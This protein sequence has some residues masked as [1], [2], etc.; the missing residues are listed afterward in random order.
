[1]N[2]KLV[3]IKACA[4]VLPGFSTKTAM[5]HETGGTHQL[6]LARHLPDCGPYNFDP[7]DEFRILPR[8]PV[9]S[10]LVSSG[11][12]LFMSRGSQNRAVLLGSIP[13]PT[14]APASFYILKTKPVVDPA[15]LAW[16][17]NQD[18]AQARI[19][20]IRTGA[21]TLFVPR[22]DFS[23]IEIALPSLKEQRKIAELYYLM[24]QERMLLV[25][26]T[27]AVERKQRVVGKRIIRALLEKEGGNHVCYCPLSESRQ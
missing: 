2:I 9:E 25:R 8:T 10:Y 13:Q 23:E 18:P 6:L 1:M 12:L 7:K 24:A 20:E 27:M 22:G 14:L 15:Y 19:T 3:P 26:M 17:L 21:G 11:D 16:Y 4:E 5:A